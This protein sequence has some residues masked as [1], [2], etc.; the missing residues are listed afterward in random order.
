[1]GRVAELRANIS[2]HNQ[3]IV[4]SVSG[5]ESSWASRPEIPHTFSYIYT[6]LHLKLP[7]FVLDF[8]SNTLSITAVLPPFYHTRNFA[9]NCF[10]L[11]LLLSRDMLLLITM[12]K[13]KYVLTNLFWDSE[14][15]W[16]VFSSA[17]RWA[18]CREEKEL[19]LLAVITQIML[20]YS[21]LK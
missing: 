14:W 21:S 12:T 17:K 20:G 8:S 19:S 3:I 1:M 9:F 6:Y 16:I 2:Q 7:S 10:K 5:E 11:L 18:I 15:L 4:N 13:E